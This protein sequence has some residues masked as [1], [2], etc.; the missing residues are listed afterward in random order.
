[1]VEFGLEPKTF[2]GHYRANVRRTPNQ[3][4]PTTVTFSGPGTLYCD[5]VVFCHGLCCYTVY[6]NL[7]LLPLLFPPGIYFPCEKTA[8]NSLHVVHCCKALVFHL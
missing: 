3:P 5:D 1:M 7:Y 6:L 2:R 4:G 8:L